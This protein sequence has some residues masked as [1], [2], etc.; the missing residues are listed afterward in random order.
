MTLET[1]VVFCDIDVARGDDFPPWMTEEPC[2]FDQVPFQ[3]FLA[4]V[5]EEEEE[6]NQ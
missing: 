6:Q 1:T 5:L 2:N 3:G 4:A